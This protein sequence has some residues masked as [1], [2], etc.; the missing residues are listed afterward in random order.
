MSFI[1]FNFYPLTAVLF[2]IIVLIQFLLKK[3]ERL[4][5]TVSKIILLCFSYLVMGLYDWRF[6]LCMTGG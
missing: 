2:V 3:K 6:C 1:D 4:S 5:N